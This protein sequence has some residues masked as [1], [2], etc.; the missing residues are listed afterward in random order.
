MTLSCLLHGK[1]SLV[2]Q[3][4]QTPGLHGK[5]PTTH[6]LLTGPEKGSVDRGAKEA[7]VSGA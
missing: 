6:L 7:A 2:L 3:C 1:A 4:S 5:K